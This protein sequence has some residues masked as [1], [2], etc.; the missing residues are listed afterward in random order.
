MG[1]AAILI[2]GPWS[3]EQCFN[4]PLTEGPPVKFEETWPSAFRGESV[5]NS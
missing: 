2:N 5:Q 3:F 1:M 4:P